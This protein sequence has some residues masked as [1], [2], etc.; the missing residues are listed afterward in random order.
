[1]GIG[2]FAVWPLAR[3][4]GKRNVTLAGFILYAA[5]GMICWMHPTNMT[6]MLIGQ[7]IKKYRRTSLLLCIYGTVCRCSGSYGM[8]DGISK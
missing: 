6:I 4:F 3:R 1:M 5:G 7:L 8:E 2:I